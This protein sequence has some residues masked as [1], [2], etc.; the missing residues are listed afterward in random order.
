[1]DEAPTQIHTVQ[2]QLCSQVVWGADEKGA[3]LDHAGM[4]HMT[5]S[6]Q[7]PVREC[8]F[9]AED[10]CLRAQTIISKHLVSCVCRL[11][12]VLLLTG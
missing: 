1:M 12:F 10:D 9:Q 5:V 7:C 3:K 8:H 2:C 6:L 11:L 4:E